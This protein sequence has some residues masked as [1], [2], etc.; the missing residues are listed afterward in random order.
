MTKDERIAY[1][2]SLL[3]PPDAT[4]REK[5]AEELLRAEV[6]RLRSLVSALT[7]NEHGHEWPASE[8]G[9]DDPDGSP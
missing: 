2:E 3:F 4:R 7:R 9:S 6:V 5:S 8:T 1:L